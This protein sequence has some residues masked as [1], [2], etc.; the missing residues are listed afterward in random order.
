[1]LLQVC[2]KV[3]DREAAKGTLKLSLGERG[4]AIDADGRIST[5][6]GNTTT[7]G[8]RAYW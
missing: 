6:K 4:V 1:M 7:A 5:D 3:V 2:S 8:A